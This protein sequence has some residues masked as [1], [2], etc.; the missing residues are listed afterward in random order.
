M[1]KRVP[2]ASSLRSFFQAQWDHLA[3][4]LEARQAE[5]LRNHQAKEILNEAV[6]T[7]VDWTDAR[8]RGVSG[9]RN[10]LRQTTRE[11]LEHIE[12]IADRITTAVELSRTA[13]INDPLVHL[14]FHS[15][16]EMQDMFKRSEALQGMCDNPS[17]ADDDALFALLFVTL[18][19][20]RILGAEMRGEMLIKDVRQT[21][22]SFAA[23]RL[24][25]PCLDEQQARSA[26][27]RT[28]FE[29]VVDYLEGLSLQLRY[30]HREQA[31][32]GI[33]IDPTTSIDNPEVYLRAL[34]EQMLVPQRLIRLH[35]KLLRVNAM[36]IKLPQ[37]SD[38][39]DEPVRLHE[40][41]VGEGRSQ[42]LV[43]VKIPR[44][45][46]RLLPEVHKLY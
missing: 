32:R 34:K 6:E 36:G 9:Y 26:L 44:S 42:V 24:V 16:S 35:D 41:E 33:R 22:V 31:G 46:L 11:L 10:E 14:L 29:S 4:L 30:D 5:M 1:R 3:G 43:L 45:E 2:E 25:A 18:K 19:E 20:K 38:V 27:K 39:G 12:S 7:I 15:P 23:H 13:H 21:L 28:L 17:S 37:P 8:M 40:L